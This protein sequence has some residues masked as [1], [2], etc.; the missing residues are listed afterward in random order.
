MQIDFHHAVTYVVA[1]C[2]GFPHDDAA[3]IAY[4]AQD[5]DD[6]IRRCATIMNSRSCCFSVTPSLR[7]LRRRHLL[8]FG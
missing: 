7:E 5:V 2:A 4:A 1:R 8:V 6:A 3:V